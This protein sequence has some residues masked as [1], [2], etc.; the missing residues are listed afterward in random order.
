M[1]MY[2]CW[3]MVSEMDMP[4][5]GGGGIWVWRGIWGCDWISRALVICMGDGVYIEMG[6]YS[7]MGCMLMWG[8]GYDWGHGDG[9]YICI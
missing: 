5:W 3:D 2:M 6:M 1:Y 9:L 7:E 8:M 4:I